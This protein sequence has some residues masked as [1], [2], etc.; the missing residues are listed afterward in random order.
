MV[1]PAPVFRHRVPCVAVSDMLTQRCARTLEVKHTPVAT[2]NALRGRAYMG[3]QF[4]VR[5]VKPPRCPADPELA[6][7]HRRR[8]SSMC[9]T[10]TPR[11]WASSWTMLPLIWCWTWCGSCSVRRQACCKRDK[12]VG[13]TGA[14]LAASMLPFPLC[15]N[16]GPCV[17]VLEPL[18]SAWQLEQCQGTDCQPFSF[19]ARCT[20][21]CTH[22]G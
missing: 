3:A 10:P 19:A 5:P 22:C 15:S 4:R 9:R 2:A 6:V 8:R 13:M 1:R 14:S 18:P 12:K 17:A 20:L 21:E 16:A 7:L 11:T